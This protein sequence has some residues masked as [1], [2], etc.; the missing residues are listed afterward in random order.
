MS[1]LPRLEKNKGT[2]SSAL[3]KSLAREVLDGNHAILNEAIE[4]VVY[5]ASHSKG[6]NVRS[7]AAKIVELVAEQQPEL[8]APFLENLLPALDVVEPQTRWMMIRTLGYCAD[9]K[10]EVAMKG[11][12]YAQ[13]FIENKEGICLSAATAFFLGD[14]GILSKENARQ[15]HLLLIQASRNAVRN[16]VDWILEAFIKIFPLLDIQEQN[17]IVAYARRFE[18][19]LRKSTQ[20]RVRKIIQLE[21]KA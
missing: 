20:A 9:Y 8:V 7:G 11:I 19:T 4:L 1:I 21:R 2:L 17:E 18:D 10:P 6:K 5:Q 3:G 14:V 12:P 13:R 15:S 16:D